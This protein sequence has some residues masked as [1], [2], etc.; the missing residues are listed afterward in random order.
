MRAHLV[1]FATGKGTQCVQLVVSESSG[2]SDAHRSG[3]IAYFMSGWFGPRA[4]QR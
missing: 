3:A 4:V 2:C 1:K